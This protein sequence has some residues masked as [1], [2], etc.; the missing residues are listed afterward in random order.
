MRW[1][2]VEYRAEDLFKPP[3][4]DGNSLEEPT[5]NLGPGPGQRLLYA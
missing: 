3:R 1:S 2:V 5:D 4:A